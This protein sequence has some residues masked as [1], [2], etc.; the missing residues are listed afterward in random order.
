[1]AEITFQLDQ[2]WILKRRNCAVVEKRDSFLEDDSDVF[3]GEI[4]SIHQIERPAPY[5][6]GDVILFQQEKC[7]KVDSVRNIFIVDIP[8]ILALA[9]I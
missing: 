5:K 1:M 2:K 8:E 3:E 6:Q 4:I 7:F 9:K